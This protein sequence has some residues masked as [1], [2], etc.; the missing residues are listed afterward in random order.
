MR[1]S[2]ARLFG[3]LFVLCLVLLAIIYFSISTR[4]TGPVADP[5]DDLPPLGQVPTPEQI[6]GKN[7]PPAPKR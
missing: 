5:L 6:H 7:P 1:K 4:P 2:N 3:M